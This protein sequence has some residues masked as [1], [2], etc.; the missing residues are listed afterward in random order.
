LYIDAASYAA[1]ALLQARARYFLL[2]LA[3]KII[4]MTLTPLIRTILK[5]RIMAFIE[6]QLP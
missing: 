6:L 3:L 1:K 2:S 5:A 4:G